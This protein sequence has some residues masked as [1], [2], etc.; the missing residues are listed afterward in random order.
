MPRKQQLL[1][2]VYLLPCLAPSQHV[3]RVSLKV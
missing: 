2:L 1:F 3:K